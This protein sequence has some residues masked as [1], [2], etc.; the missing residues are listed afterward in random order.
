MPFPQSNR[1]RDR[2]HRRASLLQPGQILLFTGVQI[3]RQD[4]DQGDD[5]GTPS[6]TSVGR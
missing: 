3:V 6:E 2:N 4:E 5:D 1:R